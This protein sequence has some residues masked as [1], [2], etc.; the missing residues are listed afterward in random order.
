M[1][2]T[3]RATRDARGARGVTAHNR[4]VARAV[5]LAHR[6]AAAAVMPPSSHSAWREY[7]KRSVKLQY[8][9]GATPFCRAAGGGGSAR[10]TMALC[11]QARIRHSISFLAALPRRKSMAST[12][13]V[14]HLKPWALAA[15]RRLGVTCLLSTHLLLS[16]CGSSWAEALENISIWRHRL[17]APQNSILFTPRLH[18]LSHCFPSRQTSR[19]GA[20]Q[21]GGA[22]RQAVITALPSG[23]ADKTGKLRCGTY[24]KLFFMHTRGLRLPPLLDGGGRHSHGGW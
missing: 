22:R 15:G 2:R 18:A 1:A 13:Y 9:R 17:R 11:R 16:H 19:W 6:T 24:F 10:A 20:E 7:Q 3:N 5:W 23:A 8:R 14:G 21:R 12:I 4:D